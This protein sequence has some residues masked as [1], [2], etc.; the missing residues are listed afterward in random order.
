[1]ARLDV[2]ELRLSVDG[3]NPALGTK[4]I[5]GTLTKP[6]TNKKNTLLVCLPGGSYSRFY[7]QAEFDDFK[8][9]NFANYMAGKG[10]MVLTLDHL[11]MGESDKP[12]EVSLL[13]KSSIAA[14][15]HAAVQSVLEDMDKRPKIVGL[16]HSMGGMA[17]VEQQAKFA[18]FDRIGVLGWTN[19]GLSLGSSEPDL[20]ADKAHYAPTDRGLMRPLF[21]L[22][23]VPSNLIEQDDTRAS[24]TPSPF[25]QQAVQSGIVS[26]EAANIKCP[27][28]L[29]FGEV[30]ISP[31]PKDEPKFYRNAQSVDLTLLAGSAHNHNFAATRTQLWDKIGTFA[32]QSTF[33]ET[34]LE[35]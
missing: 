27:V 2:R 1:M 4:R 15:N 18:T 6:A 7:F 9:Y 28:F 11:G 34:A 33:H 16:G 25:A 12:E 19:I 31:Q 13:D 3:G 23:D 21:H 8:G 30:D 32:S 26:K 17:V 24:L 29:A 5:A 10:F 20:N 14:F 22:P 35:G